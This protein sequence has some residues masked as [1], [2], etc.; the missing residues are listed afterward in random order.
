[1]ANETDNLTNWHNSGQ[2]FMHHGYD[3]FYQDSDPLNNHPTDKPTVLLI[4]G[5][6]TASWDWHKIWP[7]LCE[8]YRVITL[9]MIGFGFSS[10]PV[11][12]EYSIAKQASLFEALLAYLNITLCHVVAHD[13]GDT[14]A[15]ELLARQRERS[16]SP[17]LRFNS[18]TLLNGGLFPETHRAKGIQKLLNSPLGKIIG[19]C[20]SKKSIARSMCDVF[21]ERTQ[22]SEQ[23]LEDFWQLINGRGGWQV[24]H[25]L[26]RYMNERIIHRERWV[27]AL[28]HSPC[29]IQIINGS[30]DTI[31]GEHMVQRYEE[32]ITRQH[33]VKLPNIG[34]Y[35]QLEAPIDVSNS[36]ISFIN[37]IKTPLA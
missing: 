30:A 29:P 7:A 5:F 18:V 17:V 1:M 28:K 21:G 2:T 12:Y 26:I 6:P 22:P 13:Y 25:K 15:Q 14:V 35:P 31:S 33:I 37:S 9:D 3:I 34:H 36:I 27:D 24:F 20:M 32:I 23:D 10:K 16:G 8:R 19:L 4:H 11:R